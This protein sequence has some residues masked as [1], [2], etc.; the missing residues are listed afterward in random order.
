MEEKA[1]KNEQIS[2]LFFFAISHREF[3]LELFNLKQFRSLT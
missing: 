3:M 2:R 1:V